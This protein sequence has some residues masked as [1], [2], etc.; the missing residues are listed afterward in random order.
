MDEAAI[1]ALCI[2]NPRSIRNRQEY[3]GQFYRNWWTGQYSYTEGRSI[4]GTEAQDTSNPYA[5]PI[6]WFTTS[7]GTFHTH[8][9]ESIRYGYGV[10]GSTTHRNGNNNFSDVDINN[11]SRRQQPSYLGTPSEGFW[12]FD[13]NGSRNARLSSNCACEK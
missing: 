3:S 9:N 5:L 12:V 7:T 4:G 10:P 6:P 8:G 1:D 2:W 13:P 11:A